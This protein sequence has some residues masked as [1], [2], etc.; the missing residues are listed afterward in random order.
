MSQMNTN[1]EEQDET[2]MRNI[3][4]CKCSTTS[5]RVRHR[6]IMYLFHVLRTRFVCFPALLLSAYGI[7]RLQDS[8]AGYS[9]GANSGF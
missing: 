6:L 1:F 9:S 3:L 5:I 2:L 7:G 4:Y 8:S